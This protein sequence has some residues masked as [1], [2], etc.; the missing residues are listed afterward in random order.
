MPRTRPPMFPKTDQKKELR[1]IV[2]EQGEKFNSTKAL[3][4][5]SFLMEFYQQNQKEVD[6]RAEEIRKKR[7]AAAEQEET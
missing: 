5:Y 4:L 7:E 3:S 6:R 2:V 1:T